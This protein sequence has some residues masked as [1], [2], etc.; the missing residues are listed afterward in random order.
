[1][2]IG[3]VSD[4]H[5]LVRTEAIDFLQGC[6]VIL[7]AGDVGTRECLDAFSA[8]APLHAVRGNVDGW[9]Q[10][11]PPCTVL[12]I[13]GV[14]FHIVHQMEDLHA[15]EA[16]GVLTC[17]LYGHSHRP[18]V[19]EW[20]GVLLLNPGSIGPKR[21]NLPISLADAVI[22][23]TT[24]TFTL[25]QLDERTQRWSVRERKVCEGLSCT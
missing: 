25:Y 5:G 8:V 10:M 11:L 6:D 3:I 4:T 17:G 12:E 15:V 24:A 9:A 18:E 2:R 21:F 20:K 13:G 1:M 14:R 23:G 19:R 16:A 22:D 7:H